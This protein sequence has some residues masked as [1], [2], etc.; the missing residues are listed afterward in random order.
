MGSLLPDALAAKPY[1]STCRQLP[2][3][4]P[5]DYLSQRGAD[6]WAWRE[7]WRA[8]YAKNPTSRCHPETKSLEQRPDRRPEMTA[9]AEAGL[10]DPRAARIGR[11]TARSSTVQRC[12]RQQASWLRFGETGRHRL[13]ER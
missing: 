10:G 5:L 9:I 2:F 6:E 1:R 12:N 13:G 11:Q 3:G 4:N 8:C 7:D